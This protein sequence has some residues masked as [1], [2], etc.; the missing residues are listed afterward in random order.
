[1][2]E[3]FE[4]LI[5]SDDEHERVVAEIYIDDK[6]VALVSQDQGIDQA[7]IEFPGTALDENQILR[8]VEV[9]DFRRAIDTATKRLAGEA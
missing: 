2:A 8:R 1:M 9:S 7:V 4:I 6:F 3:S 5:A